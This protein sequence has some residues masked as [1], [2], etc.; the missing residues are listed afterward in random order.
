MPRGHPPRRPPRSSSTKTA[1]RSSSRRSCRRAACARHRPRRGTR[2]GRCRLDA[3][4]VAEGSTHR[5][6]WKRQLRH[7]S[8]DDR[9]CRTSSRKTRSPISPR[10][11]PCSIPRTDIHWWGRNRRHKGRG[12]LRRT[13]GMDH[14]ST[15]RSQLTGRNRCDPM[16]P[17]GLPHAL[18]TAPR[19]SGSI[20][21][22][23]RPWTKSTCP[24]PSRQGPAWSHPVLRPSTLHHRTCPTSRVCASP[25]TSRIRLKPSPICPS[26]GAS[27]NVL[28]VDPSRFP[29]PGRTK[30]TRPSGQTLGPHR[31]SIHPG[32]SN[33]LSSQCPA[34][35]GLA[36]LARG[37]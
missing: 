1:A 32:A 16:H 25:Q 19:R 3:S 12:A 15:K 8:L 14:R 35:A 27:A 18:A 33:R 22:Q 34:F 28:G 24:H 13:N 2:T 17:S 30:S 36:N 21:R 26:P 11:S 5:T 4:L 29:S 10:T 9:R 6:F 31:I 20:R 7:S 23:M 37:P